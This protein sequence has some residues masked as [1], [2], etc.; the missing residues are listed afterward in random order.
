MHL[1]L[2]NGATAWSTRAATPRPPQRPR[3][4][5]F[6]TKGGLEVMGSN[7][8]SILRGSLGEDMLR[9]NGA[10]FPR[11]RAH[12]LPALHR[13]DPRGHPGAPDFARGAALQ[14]VLD[15][16]VASDEARSLDMAI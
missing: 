6:G 7:E 3:L 11:R 13:R 15:Q 16:A 14:K 5:L 12:Q 1:R 2:A 10:T 4:K 8:K 9:A